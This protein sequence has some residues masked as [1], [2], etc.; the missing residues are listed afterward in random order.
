[1]DI[2]F[3]FYLLCMIVKVSQYKKRNWKW[4]DDL[5]NCRPLLLEKPDI[6]VGTPSGI[7]GHIKAKVSSFLLAI[8]LFERRYCVR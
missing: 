4:A 6:V 8:L 5:F 2:I 7:L 3:H 1:M